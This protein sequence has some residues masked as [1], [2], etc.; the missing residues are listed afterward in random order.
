[1]DISAFPSAPER[2][3]AD[4]LTCLPAD[5]V[6]LFN[7]LAHIETGFMYA[8][9]GLNEWRDDTVMTITTVATLVR[10]LLP[11]WVMRRSTP[12]VENPIKFGSQ[13]ISLMPLICS[14]LI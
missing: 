5:F 2:L 11:A 13:A 9:I 1:L 3:I 14:C 4:H 10:E 12:A 6:R 7:Q 8:L